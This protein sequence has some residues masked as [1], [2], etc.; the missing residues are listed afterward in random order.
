MWSE[1][2][3]P[4]NRFLNAGVAGTYIQPHRHGVGKWELVNVLRGKLEVVVFTPEGKVKD[5]L[6][7]DPESASLI[8]ISG[9]EWHTFI[10][11]PPGA[12]VLEVKPGPYEPE[13]DKEFAGW[14]PAEGEPASISFLSWLEGAERGEAWLQCPHRR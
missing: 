6:G 11:H 5:R 8:E 14:A 1:L 2:T 4:I 3:D 12:V 7:L 13:L 9:G 10:F